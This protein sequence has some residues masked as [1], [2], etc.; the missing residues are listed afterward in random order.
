[1]G[2]ARG[3]SLCLGV[4]TPMGLLVMALCPCAYAHVFAQDGGGTARPQSESLQFGVIFSNV[5]GTQAELILEKDYMAL[6]ALYTPTN[7]DKWIRSW[8]WDLTLTGIRITPERS[9]P[10]MSYRWELAARA[11]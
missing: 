6:N 4:R 9:R 8:W 10:S 11:R 7:G 1:M 2:Q 5:G 3:Q